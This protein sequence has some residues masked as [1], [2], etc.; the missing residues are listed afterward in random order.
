MELSV[1]CAVMVRDTVHSAGDEENIT[2]CGLFVLSPESM[3]K[4]TPKKQLLSL[5]QVCA[6]VQTSPLG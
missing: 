1:L 4:K 3:K 2:L 5:F 6:S